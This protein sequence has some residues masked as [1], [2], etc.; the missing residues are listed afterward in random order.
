MKAKVVIIGSGI[1]GSSVA[2]HLA[3]AGWRDIL[4]LDMGDPVENPGS[5]SHAP[6]GVVAMSHSKLLTQMAVYGS[7]LYRALE[8][9]APYHRK[10]YNWVGGLDLAISERR[11]N[12]LKRLHAESKS[13]HS[14]TRLMTP[15]EIVAEKHPLLNPKAFL[16]GIFIKNGALVSGAAVSGAL[17]RDAVRMADGR[18]QVQGFTEV[19]DVETRNGHVVAVLTN[20]PEAPRIECEHVVLATNIWGP[21]LGDKLG[22][23]IPLLAYEHQYVVTSELPALA[24]FDPGNPEH[25]VVYPTVREV[26]SQFYFRQHHRAIGIGSYW[27]RALNVKP[28]DVG[29]NAMRPFTADDFDA[30]WGAM[31]SLAPAVAENTQFSRA[32]NGMFAFPVDGY[33]MIGESNTKG[34]WVAAGSWLTHAG[35]VGKT[36]AEWMTSGE[37]EWDTRQVHLHRFHAFANTRSYLD[38]VC[39]KNYEEVYAIVH[40]RQPMSRP[41]QIRVTPFYERMKAIDASFTT[42]AG[43]EAANW[44]EQNARLLEKY[45]DQIPTRSGWGGEYWS[46]IQG[47]EHLEC[48][49][50]VALFD[51]STLSVFEVKGPGALRFVDYICSNKCDVAIGKVIYTCWLTP[52]GGVRR[53]LAVTRLAPDR[54]WMFVGE[55]TRPMDW[56]WLNQHAP[57][58]GSVQLADISD[59]YSALGVWGPNARKVLE[60]VTGDDV[61]NVGF[62]YMTARWIEIG[63]ARVYAIR[64]SY[65]GELGWELHIPSDQSLQVWDALWAAGREFE[66]IA[67]GFG[68]FDSLRL[69]KGYRGWGSDVH[70]EYSPYESGL[71]WTVKLDKPG[72]FI[73]KAACAALK[74][75]PLKKKLCCLTLQ[76]RDAVLFGYEPVFGTN[77][78]TSEHAVGYVTSANFGY[79]VGKTIAF[80]YLPADHSAPGTRVEI[81]YFG[82]RFDAVVGDDPQYDPKMAKLKA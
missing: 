44:V 24:S 79:S 57:N 5:T 68:A 76:D 64:V 12:D 45:D 60:K 46:R 78:H 28:R 33:P 38:A 4:L 35:G 3:Q 73:G 54:F 53:D 62:P 29:A 25:E 26:E 39:D 40:P 37:T 82:R 31:K 66:M 17:Q 43:Y 81:E 59:A 32:F 63:A 56:H 72:D 22:V 27:H 6:G 10:T 1:V 58:D 65:A 9:H 18:M 41:R 77:G 36:L 80:A 14:E 8:P 15:E 23:P 51:L 42:F 2:Y 48:R 52:S 74:D 19:T 16:G 70:T 21:V 69:E 49:N 61:S 50:N 13:F 67:S 75:R 71:G 47:A 7:D 55:G 30:C 20:N 34:L 11:L